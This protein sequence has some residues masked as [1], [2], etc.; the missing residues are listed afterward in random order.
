[1]EKE[2]T[3]TIPHSLGKAEASRRLKAGLARIRPIVSN[4]L[5]IFDETWNEDRLEF[6]IGVLGQATCGSIDVGDKNVSV[7]LLLPSALALLA[8]KAKALIQKQ[9]LIMLETTTGPVNAHSLESFR[10]RQ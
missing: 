5:A 2:I 6:R 1:M 9:G 10:G 8:E 3:V 4:N 7:S